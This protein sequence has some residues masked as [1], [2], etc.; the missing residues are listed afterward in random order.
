MSDTGIGLD[1]SE[2]ELVFDRFFRSSR[3]V[4]QQVP[5]TGLGLFIAR[6]I[7]EAHDGTID[8]SNRDGGGTTFHIELP[9]QVASQRRSNRSSSHERAAR[10]SSRTTTTTS[11]CS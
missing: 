4:A 9:A 6:A 5:G 8:V 11:C 10:F 7:V 3:V 1:P 2:A